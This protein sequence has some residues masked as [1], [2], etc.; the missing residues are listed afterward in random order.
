MRTAGG[1]NI[2]R[3]NARKAVPIVFYSN[4]LVMNDGF[5]RPYHWPAGQA[6]VQ[7]LVDGY[8]SYELKDKHPDGVPLEVPPPPPWAPDPPSHTR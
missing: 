2:V 7:D 5:F 8:F 6:V 3:F 4:G 1:D